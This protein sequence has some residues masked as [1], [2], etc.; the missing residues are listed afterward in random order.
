MDTATQPTKPKRRYKGHLKR[1]G[2][3]CPKT[4]LLSCLAE[5]LS[6]ITEAARKA[7]KKYPKTT[8][9]MWR[10]SHYRWIKDPEY[11]KAYHETKELR[12]DFVEKHLLLMVKALV[13]SAVI[14]FLKCQG[15][16][17]G[18]DDGS[19]R[20]QTGYEPLIIEW[21]TDEAQTDAQASP[22]AQATQQSG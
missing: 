11:Y 18:W 19:T 10:E 4:F 3:D 13:P 17:R 12:L 21:P 5:S 20:V 1:V 9:K 15:R 8:L 22:G 16:E 2:P 7:A 6:N 14:F